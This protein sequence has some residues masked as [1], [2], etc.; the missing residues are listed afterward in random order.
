VKKA[1]K[2]APPKKKPAEKK[3]PAKKKTAEKKP[4]GKKTP[5]SDAASSDVADDL[6]ASGTVPEEGKD[7]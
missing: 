5:A 2:K 6:T 4:V 7:T 1:E 3:T